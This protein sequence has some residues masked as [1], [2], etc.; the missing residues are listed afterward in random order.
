MS[1]RS[2]EDAVCGRD[3]AP[4]MSA[5][6]PAAVLTMPCVGETEIALESREKRELR[7]TGRQ[8]LFASWTDT[9]FKLHMFP[10][11]AKSLSTS[12]VVL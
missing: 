8:G 9:V 11:L 3:R 12:L 4:Q 5:A 2:F 1:C 7:H 6:C 10:S